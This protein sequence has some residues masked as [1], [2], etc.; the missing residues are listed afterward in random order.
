[1]TLILA[2]NNEQFNYYRN[3]FKFNPD[4]CIYVNSPKEVQGRANNIGY[5][6]VGTWYTRENINEILDVLN[7]IQARD[8]TEEIRQK[9]NLADTWH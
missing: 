7:A 1:M 4:E 2:G 8:V 3:R 5:I 6:A 9:Y